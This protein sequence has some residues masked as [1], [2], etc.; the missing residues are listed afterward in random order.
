MCV[1]C[2]ME[3]KVSMADSL[4]VLDMYGLER[5][6]RLSSGMYGWIQVARRMPAAYMSEDGVGEAPCRVSGAM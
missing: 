4:A 5:W 6:W 1:D 2:R 3:V